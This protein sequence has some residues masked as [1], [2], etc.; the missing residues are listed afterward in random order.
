MTHEKNV[1]KYWN[2][3][4][5]E[6]MYDKYLLNLEIELIKSKL[7]PSSKI[8]DVGCGECESTMEYSKIPGVEIIGIDYSNT[9]L[10]KAQIRLSGTKNVKLLKFNLLDD[11]QLDFKFDFIISQR[12]LINILE[13]ELQKEVILKLKHYLKKGGKMLFLE[14]SVDGVIQLNKFREIFNLEPIKVK[15]HNS[16]FEDEKLE[17]FLKDSGLRLIEKNGFGE[18]FMLTRGVRPFF[19]KELEWNCKFNMYSTD[20]SLRN[21]LNLNDQLSRLKLWVVEKIV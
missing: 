15:W 4:N 5:V 6:S 7:C 13:W 1:L 9:R 18:Y 21:I 16:F 12:F 10:R 3:S 14:G 17:F 11:F 19:N 20:E 2:D 8:L